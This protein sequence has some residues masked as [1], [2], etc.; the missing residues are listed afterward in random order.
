MITG[1]CSLTFPTKMARDVYK[2]QVLMSRTMDTSSINPAS[3]IDEAVDLSM[4]LAG[5]DFPVSIF[6]TKIPVSYTHLSHTDYTG[7]W[8]Y[9]FLKSDNLVAV[10]TKVRGHQIQQ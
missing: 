3:I 4:R 5:T 10:H 2:R 9:Y 6:P 8:R 7:Y 1:L